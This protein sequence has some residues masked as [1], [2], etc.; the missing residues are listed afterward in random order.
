[1]K[2]NRLVF[3]TV[4][5]LFMNMMSPI[6]ARAESVSSCKT[7]ECYWTYLQ[8]YNANHSPQEIIDNFEKISKL[9]NGMN[10]SCNDLGRKIGSDLYNKLGNKVFVYFSVECGHSIG[11]GM[12]E[13]YGKKNK[14]IDEKLL[15]NYCL[16]DSNTPSCTFGFGLAIGK[17][18]MKKAYLS[19][20][21]NFYGY[22]K[23]KKAPDS[24]QMSARGDCFN[25][26]ISSYVNSKP[27]MN[28]VKEIEVECK[29]V[30]PLY[31]AICSGIFDYNYLSN[32]PKSL[33]VISKKLQEI[34]G[35]CTSKSGYECMQFVGK[36]TD[37]ALTYKLEIH[38]RDAKSLK[39]YSDL[40]NKI[41]QGYN[42][43][44]CITGVIQ[45]HIVH[46]SHAEMRSICSL[47]KEKTYCLKTT[48]EHV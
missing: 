38:P 8:K 9:S 19:C 32:S 34:R 1:M 28:S 29:K 48:K 43:R 15:T 11:Y 39:I 2:I 3:F 6:S 5:F 41:C 30:P 23:D 14:I 42:A 36:N 22:D 44:A 33:V 4:G 21:K 16:K 25:G 31:A 17:Y 40:I 24:F 7:K 45:S 10:G 35:E 26:F 18:D 27:P 37:Q 20:E 12:F 13:S 46:T 47:L